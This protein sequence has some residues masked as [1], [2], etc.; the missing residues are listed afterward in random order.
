[1]GRLAGKVAIVTGGGSGIGKASVLLFAAEGAS[2]VVADLNVEAGQDV[3]RLASE[4]GSR[5]VFQRADVS[6]EQDVIAMIDRAMSE[7]GRLDV[8]FNNAGVPPTRGPVTEI[9]VEEWDKTQAIC[10]RGVFL[11]IKHAV[12]PMR[13]VGGGSIIS[14]ASLGG[15]QGYE[16][17]HDYCAAKAGVVNLTRSAAIELARDMIRVNCIAP[18][19][20]STP[21]FLNRIRSS[22]KAAA[23]QVLSAIQPL[24]IA[25]Q[26][27]DIAQAALF[28]ASDASRSITGHPLVVDGGAYA[29]VATSTDPSLPHRVFM[30]AAAEP[31]A[32]QL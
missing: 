9:T 27:E 28:L 25:T 16:G 3:A 21:M 32:R 20:V 31:T 12:A 6:Q 29:G 4:S 19:G 7:F 5:C 22:D 1:M 24:P 15:L 8:L 23:D 10:L 17:K 14:T 2:V 18:G 30:S 11:G 26:P 13:Q